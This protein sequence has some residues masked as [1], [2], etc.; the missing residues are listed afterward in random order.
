MNTTAATIPLREIIGDDSSMDLV[1]VA[2]A[3]RE[4]RRHIACP[5]IASAANL[6][7]VAAD[8]IKEAKARGPAVQGLDEAAELVSRASETL[9]MVQNRALGIPCDADADEEQ[10]TPDLVAWCREVAKRTQPKAGGKM[11]GAA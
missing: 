1:E 5:Q 8:L 6:L 9:G 7:R 11:A 3:I 10:D 4:Q 2:M